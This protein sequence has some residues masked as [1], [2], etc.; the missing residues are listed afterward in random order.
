MTPH[1]KILTAIF[2]C[3]STFYIANASST[4]NM[5]IKSAP[6]ATV[7]FIN[8]ATMPKIKGTD[9]TKDMRYDITLN[10]RNDSVSLTASIYTTS[11]NPIDTAIITYNEATLRLPVEKI[12]IEPD[13]DAWLNRL[14][15]Y[16]PKSIF[17]ELLL[18]ENAPQFTWGVEPNSP[19]FRLKSDKWLSVRQTLRLADEI[20]ARNKVHEK[21]QRT[22]LDK[23]DKEIDQLDKGLN[24]AVTDLS[25]ELGL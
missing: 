21:P 18:C 24:E 5:I 20:I 2:C 6:E 16:L 12:F 4:K 10:T 3:L 23:L 13:D 15:V 14:R 8:P 19:A 9:A 1:F 25:N 22:I 7:V 11:A 17:D